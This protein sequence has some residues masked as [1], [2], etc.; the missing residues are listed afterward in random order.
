MRIVGGSSPL[1]PTISGP[2]E[3][4]A[5]I[6]IMGG[7][8][9]ARCE[10][11]RLRQAQL[12]WVDEDMISLALAAAATPSHEPIRARRMPAE[13]GL[14][15]FAHPIGS[16]DVDLAAALTSPWTTAI[17]DLDEEL[18]LTFPVVGVSWSRWSPADLDLDGAPGRIRWSPRTP[19]GAAPLTPEFDGVWIDLLDHGQ[20]GLGQPSLG[21][22]SGH[23]HAHGRDAH[24]CRLGRT[25]SSGGVRPA[26]DLRRTRPAIR[27]TAAPPRSGQRK[28]VGARG[29]H[30]VAPD[31]TDRQRPAHRDR[32]RAPSTS[33]PQTRP[34]G[35]HPRARRRAAGSGAHSPPALG[36][37]Q[38]RGHGSLPR[39]P[40]TAVDPPLASSPLPAQ[41]VPQP[42]RPRRGRMR[43]RGASRAAHIKGPADKP[44]VTTDRVHIWDTPPP[45]QP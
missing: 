25:R 10:Q 5:A 4:T 7:I 45:P 3:E 29:L 40:G 35:R 39:P 24:R 16:H 42:T 36:A 43:A 26:A 44:L 41:H 23:R 30:R 18:R 20:Q 21:P 12:Y 22:A 2:P 6:D 14:M 33:R 9:M 38:R 32:N 34:A 11:R 8:L 28:P 15:L 31:G 1:V 13:A 17:P 19:Q 37:G 27:P